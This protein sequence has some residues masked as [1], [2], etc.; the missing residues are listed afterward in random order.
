MSSSSNLVVMKKMVQQL[1]FEASINRVKVSQ[2]A[3]D[4][5]HGSAPSCDLS[6]P[7]Y[8]VRVAGGD[9]GRGGAPGCF[10]KKRTQHEPQF[11]LPQNCP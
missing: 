4:L 10:R 6:C 11:A 1:R 3:A 8:G 7:A 9:T 5:Q 2:A